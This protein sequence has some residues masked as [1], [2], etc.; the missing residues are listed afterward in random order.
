MLGYITFYTDGPGAA[1]PS[2]ERAYQLSPRSYFIP[3]LLKVAR[4]TENAG[5]SNSQGM[6]E[7]GARVTP[8]QIAPR[9]EALPQDAPVQTNT[10]QMR[11]PGVRRVVYADRVP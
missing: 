1:A 5:V 10:R 6:N 2:L 8:P 9:R 11:R 7:P 4:L 3:K